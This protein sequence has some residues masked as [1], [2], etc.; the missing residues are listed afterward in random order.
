MRACSRMGMFVEGAGDG[1]GG[2]CIH[3][4]CL[5]AMISASNCSLPWLLN[6]P[7]PEIFTPVFQEGKEG[8]K[9][10]KEERGRKGIVR[11]VKQSGWGL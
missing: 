6:L 9:E 1:G 10:G 5:F 8:G 7:D 4:N 3:L 2:A 11:G